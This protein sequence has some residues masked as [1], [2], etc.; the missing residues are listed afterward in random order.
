MIDSREAAR[1]DGHVVAEAGGFV[2]QHLADALVARSD[3]A[4]RQRQ[5]HGNASCREWHPGLG[6][7]PQEKPAKA[8]RRLLLVNPTMDAIGAE[9]MM[10]DVPLRLE[11]LAAYI[12]PFVEHVAVVDLIKE[13]RPLAYFLRKHRP[14]LVGVTL[15]YIS[16]HRT[17]LLLAAE[18]K[19]YG[20]DV[21]YGG[22]LA[23]A[24]A[25]EFAAEQHVDF[26]VR[27]EGEL[28]LRELVEGRPAKDILGLSYTR[29]G[30]VVHNGHRPN[31]EDLDS[32]PF[33]QRNRRRYEYNFPFADLEPDANT[34]YEMIITSR[35]CWGRCTFCTEPIMSRGKQRYRS[36]KNVIAEIEKLV[37][38]HRGKR[39]RLF[40]A[41]PNFGGDLRIAHELCDQ[42]IEFRKRCATRVN[43]FVTVRTSTVAKHPDLV[44][45]LCAAGVD[46]VFVGMES[47]KREDLKAIRK[48]GGAAEEQGKAVQFLRESGAAVMSCFLLGLPN[49]TEQDIYAMVDYAR[50]LGLEDAYFA[51]MCP[52]PGSQLYDET[53]ARGELLEPDHRKW[54]LYDLVIKHE[55]VSPEKMR[56]ICVRC[57][58]KWYDD[59]MLPQ[60]HRRWLRDGRRKRKLYDF[61][62]KFG[63][64][65][66]FFQFLGDSKDE[67]SA[68]DTFML[69]KEM[70]N[71][72]LRA[73]TTL[74]PIHEMFEMGRFLRILGDQK[75]QI[76][77]R[78]SE[79]RAVSW[80]L[81]AAGGRVH[82][83]DCIDGHVGDATVSVNLDLR[84]GSPEPAAVARQ[85]L[86]DNA[87]WR[88]RLGVVRLV[89]ATASE[90]GACF[91]NRKLEDVR[92]RL[93]APRHLLEDGIAW[94]RGRA[95]LA[96][97]AAAGVGEAP[98][99]AN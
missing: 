23:T 39:L 20:A 87:G 73:F 14:D 48:G 29:D 49:Q 63:L 89:A 12:R 74:H 61:A 24:L 46:Y 97:P 28:T 76:T 70:P 18:A 65:L 92:H 41:D 43:L 35:G 3:E 77:L 67:L 62:S 94:V 13:K 51:V 8:Y 54:K 37:R 21:V 31:I 84:G 68:L 47:P 6:S 95:G 9:F 64:L 93:R 27:G 40:I 16:V 96:R 90:V 72:R 75:L 58:S 42:L 83:V 88:A 91:A 4:A 19:Q 86:A 17:S 11:Y 79:G 78:F 10:E 33:P 99:H 2:G 15:N 44:H 26:V 80:V 81:E 50:S 56:E 5:S 71:E 82:Y 52:L 34:A 55:H 7:D 53:K 59:L 36:P 98:G 66:G 25:A 32:L 1:K 45:K 57:N 38:L 60:A 22:Y 85:I 69:V 30:E